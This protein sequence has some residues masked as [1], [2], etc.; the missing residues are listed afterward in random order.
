VVAKG[1]EEWEVKEVLDC[2]AKGRK[3]EYLISWKGFGPQDNFWEPEAHVTNCQDLINQFNKK[4]PG[5]TARHKR[6]R[7]R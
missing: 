2:R 7:R 4:F 5:A 6:S 3:K 1:K